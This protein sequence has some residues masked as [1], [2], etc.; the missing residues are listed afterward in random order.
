MFFGFYS[1]LTGNVF[2]PSDGLFC[3]FRPCSVEFSACLAADGSS[4][5]CVTLKTQCQHFFSG[6][7][8][9]KNR[10]FMDSC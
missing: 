2:L 1:A 10:R 8:T 3:L 4:E 6:H 5:T 9:D 7:Y